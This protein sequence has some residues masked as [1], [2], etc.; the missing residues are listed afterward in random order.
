MK[1]IIFDLDGTLCDHGHRSYLA[2]LKQWD[3]YN[4]QCHADPPRAVELLILQALAHAGI[5]IILL[6][7]RSEPYRQMTMEWLAK[8]EVPYSL[9]YMRQ[10]GDHRPATVMK[11]EVYE[12][13]IRLGREVIAIFEDDERLVRMWRDMGLTCFQSI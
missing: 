4:A 9:L 7:G 2:D 13:E 12:T 5:P 10:D 3:L 6:T 8:H 1:V 11:R